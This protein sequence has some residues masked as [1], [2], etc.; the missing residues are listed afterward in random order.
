MVFAQ[1][2]AYL[3]KLHT[4]LTQLT[5][6]QSVLRLIGSKKNPFNVSEGFVESE[7]ELL[8]HALS[9][10]R[11]TLARTIY[12]NRL[13]VAF[14]F[15]Q[16]EIAADY[17]GKYSIQQA[18]LKTNCHVF[19]EGLTAFYFARR[20]SN[21]EPAKWFEI[22]ERAL[23]LF[24]TWSKH[25]TW[26]WENKMLLL[27]AECLFSK[28]EMEKAEG[29]YKLAIES[30]RRHRFVHEEGLGNDLLSMFHIANGNVDKAKSHM[31]QARA[32]YEKWGASAL[33]ELLDS[34]QN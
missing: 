12:F 6:H 9:T 10:G 4:C 26:N 11:I 2:Q 19:Y 7:D 29:Q 18:E 24:E 23:R 30:A 22:G 20:S 25:S 15:K 31:S 3:K 13:F 1:M 28:G 21:N 16:Y 17:A 14:F 34:S 32:C 33:V 5:N 27:E 8:H